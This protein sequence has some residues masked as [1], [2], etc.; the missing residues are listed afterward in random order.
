M[1]CMCICIENALSL[2]ISWLVSVLNFLYLL[3]DHWLAFVLS[4]LLLLQTCYSVSVMRS[5]S[6]SQV[7]WLYLYIEMLFLML[8][9]WLVFV[10]IFSYCRF[11]RSTLY[12]SCHLSCRFV[13]LYL[14]ASALSAEDNTSLQ[15]VYHAIGPEFLKRLLRPLHVPSVSIFIPFITI[16]NLTQEAELL[17]ICLI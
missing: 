11:I 7:C 12:W 14:T 15:Q 3:Q 5:C 2:Q 9:Y 13:G 1:A 17:N 10:A 6:L 8:N 16:P 4:F